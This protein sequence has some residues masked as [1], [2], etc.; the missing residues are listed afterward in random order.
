MTNISFVFLCLK[1][2]SYCYKN[3][4]DFSRATSAFVIFGHRARGQIGRDV[5][6]GAA[7]VDRLLIPRPVKGNTFCAF[8]PISHS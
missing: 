6:A 5:A 1:S 3:D 7:A 4:Y 8:L 2:V